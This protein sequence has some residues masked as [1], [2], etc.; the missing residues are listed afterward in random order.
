MHLVIHETLVKMQ[1][2]LATLGLKKRTDAHQRC[3]M[4]LGS[5][6]NSSISPCCHFPQ[7]AN[8]SCP[9][10]T[11]P[12]IPSTSGTQLFVHCCWKSNSESDQEVSSKATVLNQ[13]GLESI[14]FFPTEAC[15]VLHSGFVMETVSIVFWLL[16][17]SACKKGKAFSVSHTALPARRL[18][19]TRSW[20]GTQPRQLTHTNQRNIPSHLIPSHVA[21]Q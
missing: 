17:S 15:M 18:G 16:L 14:F 19:C 3:N 11:Q 13:V 20:E 7:K 5:H 6:F 9:S 12:L 10:N 21:Q 4:G 1:S 2:L 8:P